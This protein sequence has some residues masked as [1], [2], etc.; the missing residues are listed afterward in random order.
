MTI[1]K[2]GSAAELMVRGYALPNN[3]F[4]KGNISIQNSFEDELGDIDKADNSRAIMEKIKQY[5]DIDT[6]MIEPDESEIDCIKHKNTCKSTRR[7]S[8]QSEYELSIAATIITTQLEELM[9]KLPSENSVTTRS[10]PLSH[11][12][13]T[14]SQCQSIK[15]FAKLISVIRNSMTRLSAEVRLRSRTPSKKVFL[16][17]ELDDGPDGKGSATG[18]NTIK[19]IFDDYSAIE[20]YNLN[21]GSSPVAKHNTNYQS[22]I[23]EATSDIFNFI[24]QKQK[25][26]LSN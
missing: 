18:I 23:R 12:P 26:Y 21:N 24:T 9:D 6:V 5:Y 13:T 19:S 4:Y 11:S 7:R 15:S 10:R 3:Y 25:E 17:S 2:Y 20:Q 22:I 8:T 14:L 1:P 16:F